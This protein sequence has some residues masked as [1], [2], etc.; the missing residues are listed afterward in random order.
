MDKL[1]GGR[2]QLKRRIGAGS[3]GEIYEGEDVKSGKRVAVKLEK[4][5]TQIPQLEAESKVYHTISGCTNAASLYYFGIEIQTCAL[6]IDFLSN[7][8]ESLRVAGSD[9]RLSSRSVLMLAPQMISAIEFLHRMN[10]IHGDI[11]P[12]NFMMG[13]GVNSNKVYM[14]DFGLT[15]H[16]RDPT[17]HQHIPFKEHIPFS[18]TA[19]YASAWALRGNEQ[20]RRDDMEAL[21]YVWLWLLNG[22]VPWMNVEGNS[23]TA[24]Y[25]KMAALKVRATPEKLFMGHPPEFA[26]YLKEVRKLRFQDEPNYNK[27]RKMFYDAFIRLGYIWDEKY[28]WDSTIP[29]SNSLTNIKVQKLHI[30]SP[31]PKKRRIISVNHNAM[32]TNKIPLNKFASAVAMMKS[33]ALVINKNHNCVKD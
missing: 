27:F 24:K 28:E 23:M 13:N 29:A 32:K 17:T 5:K 11:K 18:G 1:V 9:G 26:L 6:V 16:Y 3:F 12:E 7:S 8:L 25:E 19:R 4:L 22:S 20:S 30:K 21:A 10:M 2:Y 14:I 33:P 15:R 31:E